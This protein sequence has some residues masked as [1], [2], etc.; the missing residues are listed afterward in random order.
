LIRRLEKDGCGF[1]LIAP[2]QGPSLVSEL[3][4]VSDD[5]LAARAHGEKGFSLG[6]FDPAYVARFP[7]AVV[8]R[9]NRVVAFAVVWQSADHAELSV[10]LMRFSGQ[11]PRS[12]MEA[13][14]AHLLVWGKA[15]GYRWFS[16]GMAPLA[17]V[18][19]G[20]VAPLWNRFGSFVY[21]H[22]GSVYNFQGL[23]GFKAKFDP[24]WTP[25][26]LVYPGGTNLPRLLT[27]LAA[28]VAGGYRRLFRR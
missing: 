26:Y 9:G 2:P 3:R 21:R 22:G 8:R 1:D 7:V 24:V 25:R 4:G 5:W 27:D 13:L 20:P 23:R 17:G 6:F 28:L 10:D 18:A 14:F 11:A 16:L 19:A 15:Q 12:A